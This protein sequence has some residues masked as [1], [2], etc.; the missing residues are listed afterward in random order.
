TIKPVNE[1][2]AKAHDAGALVLLDGAQAAP[3]LAIDVQQLD[4]DFYAFSGHKLYGPTG[5]GVL[6]G[7]KQLLDA[8]PPYQGGGEMI[9]RV[10]FKKTT[11]NDLPFKFEAGTPNIIG[12]IGLAE[13]I[14]YVS[15]FD[16]NDLMQH[17]KDLLAYATERLLEIPSLRIIGNATS[18]V[19][20]ISFLVADHHPLDIGML[21]DQQ[22]IA[23]RTGH[24]CTQ[25]LMDFYGISGT[26]R[27]YFTFYN[28]RAE[29]D[30][31]V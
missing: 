2:I 7:K 28:T 21:L 1:I 13:A 19:S 9:K 22:G 4:V 23:V 20:V 10:T 12:G 16:I 5:V 15:Q 3:H 27:A 6:Y 31:L 25:P 30:A 26:A 17:E 24:H 14:R 18:K 29:V 11:F 8:M